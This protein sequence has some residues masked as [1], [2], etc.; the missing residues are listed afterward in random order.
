MDQG[1][2]PKIKFQIFDIKLTTKMESNSCLIMK[3]I[4]RYFL[5]FFV[6]LV[7]SFKM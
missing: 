4:E 7:N 6:Y 3:R 1:K 5:F 2:N